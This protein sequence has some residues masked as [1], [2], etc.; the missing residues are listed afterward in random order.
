MKKK[1]YTNKLLLKRVAPLLTMCL[2][3]FLSGY[4]S[5]Q[6]GIGGK[7]ENIFLKMMDRMMI[8]MDEAPKGGPVEISF[9]NQMIPHHK[10]AV[11]MAEYEIK[12]GKNF[13]VIQ[14]A[15]SILAEQDYEL[16]QM[17]IWLAQWKVS[18]ARAREGFGKAM[19]KTMVVMMQDLPATASLTDTDHDFAT[20][21]MPHHQA[22]VDMAKVLLRYSNDRHISAFAEHIISSQQV[23]IEQMNFFLKK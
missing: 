13:E 5:R 16:M 7:K 8:E 22:A 19:S 21:M 17:Q 2:A 4:A 12:H 11:E 23:E 14:L 10:G 1:S 18:E 15:K 3:L 20:V 9:L 6:P